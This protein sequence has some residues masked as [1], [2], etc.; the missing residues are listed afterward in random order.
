MNA[1]AVARARRGD[2]YVGLWDALLVIVDDRG[3]EGVTTFKP[4]ANLDSVFTRTERADT[5]EEYKDSE[6]DKTNL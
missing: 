6:A 4:R 2:G 3:V 5:G 1:T